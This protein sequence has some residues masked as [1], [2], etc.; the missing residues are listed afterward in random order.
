MTESGATSGSSGWDWDEALRSLTAGVAQED[1]AEFAA[2]VADRSRRE[3]S[4][5]SLADRL[6]PQRGALLVVRVL[7]TEPLR[8]AL[9]DIGP[10]WLLLTI[11]GARPMLVPLASVLS[12]RGLGPATGVA[13]GAVRSRLGLA[14]ALRVLARDRRS[15]VLHLVDG[16]AV[17]GMIDRVGADFVEL[18]EQPPGEER[19]S[20]DVSVLAVPFRALAVVA[21]R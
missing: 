18:A 3:A 6:P 2:E 10:D 9:T 14:Y 8:G 13:S 7:G 5:V 19:R 17:P 1:R 15:V 20:R 21:G 4:L 11:A 16:F 12:I